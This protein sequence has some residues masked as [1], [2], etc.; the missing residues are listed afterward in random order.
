MN[1]TKKRIKGTQIKKTR[2]TKTITILKKKKK[3]RK[4]TMMMMMKKKT[5][6]SKMDL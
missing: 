4:T 2:K 3:K 6:K 5:E 1:Q